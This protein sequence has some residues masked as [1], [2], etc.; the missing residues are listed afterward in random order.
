[1]KIKRR[2]ICFLS[3]ILALTA[4]LSSCQGGKTPTEQTLATT[5][6]E[7]VVCASHLDANADDLCDSCGISV[8]VVVDFYAINDLHGKLDDTDS[9]PG[10]DELTTYLKNAKKSD[11][12]AVFLSSGDMWQ[13]SAESNLTKGLIITDWMNA[14]DFASMTLG[15]HEFDWGED[16]IEE[17]DAL[18]EFPFLAINIYDRETNQRVSYAS[19]SVMVD[20]TMVAAS[21]MHRCTFSGAISVRVGSLTPSA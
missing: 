11:D 8:V 3:L 16:F 18:A 15:N 5:G 10:V 2:V 13:G 6:G 1:M 19:A 4:M 7:A 14:L 17:N 9:Q 12:H 20:S 21:S